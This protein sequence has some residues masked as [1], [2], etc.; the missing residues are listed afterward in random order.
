[1]KRVNYAVSRGI[2]AAARLYGEILGGTSGWIDGIRVCRGVPSWAYPRGGV[3]WGDTVLTGSDPRLI[4][5]DRLR[6]EKVH[7]DQ[8][9]RYG[10]VFPIL[11]FAAGNDPLKNKYERRAGLG[12]GG[13]R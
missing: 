13:Y 5:H 6:H 11:Y 3:C 12:D 4:T 2:G 9:R 1:M 7:R 8:W 10:I